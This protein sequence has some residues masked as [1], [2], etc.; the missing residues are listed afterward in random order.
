MKIIDEIIRIQAIFQYAFV[1]QFFID[2]KDLPKWKKVKFPI[3]MKQENGNF[4]YLAGNFET[5]A[6]ANAARKKMRRLGFK[7]AFV[8]AYQAGKRVETK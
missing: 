2:K 6:Q 3:E 7:G 4:K 1:V 5:L 8:V